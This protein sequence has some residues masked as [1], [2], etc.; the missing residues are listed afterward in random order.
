M[1]VW[2]GVVVEIGVVFVTAAALIF[3]VCG[4]VG[5]RR[6]GSSRARSRFT[7]YRRPPSYTG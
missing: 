3:C 7:V 1:F 6:P 5:C 2:V 4:F